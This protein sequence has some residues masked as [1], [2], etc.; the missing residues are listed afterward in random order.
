MK[1]LALLAALVAAGLGGCSR[2]EPAAAPGRPASAAAAPAPRPVAAPAAP[3][4]FADLQAVA[5]KPPRDLMQHAGVAAELR[6]IVP[7][8]VFKCLDDSFDAMRDLEADTAGVLSS[9]LNGSHADQFMEGYVR[10]E[11]SGALDLVL[12][13]EP[14]N[15]PKGPY[16]YYTN[17][18]ATAAPPE[19]LLDWLYVVGQ[20]G[21]R[22]VKAAG[23]ARSEMEFEAFMT[24]A[25][26][27]ARAAAHGASA[28][29]AAPV[30]ASAERVPAAAAPDAAPAVA[31][32]TS[33]DAAGAAANRA[34]I[35]ASAE[36][37]V[38]ASLSNNGRIPEID[39]I[40]RA[41]NEAYDSVP[42][43]LRG[44]DDPR[45]LRKVAATCFT[46]ATGV[47]STFRLYGA[48]P[49]CDVLRTLPAIR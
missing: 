2:T 11:P 6:R 9:L 16:L 28:P 31:A 44:S 27:P 12:Q 43:E 37:L 48:L 7:Q 13:C 23:S 47:C 34:V 4:P 29:A 24:A 36:V 33:S 42:A 35:K 30:Q 25:R 45:V 49:Q 15:D 32:S 3:Q 19:Q 22:V 26:A 38:R 46:G 21:A 10:V 41:C 14:M 17:R 5:G 40:V 20:P 8:P 18:A 1:R 39:A